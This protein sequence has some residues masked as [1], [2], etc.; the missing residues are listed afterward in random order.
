MD[1]EPGNLKLAA[2]WLRFADGIVALTGAGISAESGIATFRDEGGFWDRFPPEQF[3]TWDG[4]LDTFARSP[5]GLAEFL[6]E[7]LRPVAVA[8]PNPAHLAL[9][10]LERHRPVTIVTQNV[11]G[12]HQEA[13]STDVKEVHGSLFRLVDA[14]GRPRGAIT[15]QRLTEVVEAIERARRGG[16]TQE[17]LLDAFQPVLGVGTADWYRPDLVMFGDRLSE[18]DWEQSLEAVRCCSVLLCVGTSGMVMPAAGLPY[19]ARAA[20]ARV[21]S[22]DPAEGYD[23]DLWL[24]GPAGQ[25]LPQLI[26]EAFPN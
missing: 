23:A 13:G 18:A 1:R 17:E 14:D 15:R 3:A 2:D 4:L 19:E 6:V 26:G 8:R 24:R 16:S 7:V 9:A 5:D 21:V 20:G 11:D 12:L 22:V 25:V 10:E